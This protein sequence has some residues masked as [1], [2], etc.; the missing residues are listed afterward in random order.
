MMCIKNEMIVFRLPY[1]Y[2]LTL[3]SCMYKDEGKTTYFFLKGSYFLTF[4]F[5][6]PGNTNVSVMEHSVPASLP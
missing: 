5:S 6:L 1:F 3:Q 2:L 4:G